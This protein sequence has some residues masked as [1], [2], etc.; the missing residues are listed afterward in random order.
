MANSGSMGLW[1]KC[2]GL[3]DVLRKSFWILGEGRHIEVHQAFNEICFLHQNCTKS[4]CFAL[5]KLLFDLFR[6]EDVISGAT[7]GHFR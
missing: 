7:S 4:V 2:N 1:T 3:I 6:S 5:K